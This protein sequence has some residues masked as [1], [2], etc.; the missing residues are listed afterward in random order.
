MRLRRLPHVIMPL[1]DEPFDSWV[2]FMAYDYGATIREMARALG[3]VDRSG[4]PAAGPQSARMW[5]TRLEV[6]QL[7]NLELT[8]GRKADEYSAMTRTVFAAHAIR[9]TSRGRISAFCPSTGVAAR[10]CPECLAD[11]GGRW[12]LSWQFPFGFACLRH[13]RLLVDV[14]PECGQPPRLVG[15]PL[16]LVP[17][18]AHCHNR[19]V[20]PNGD[21]R[22]RCGANLSA[23]AKFVLADSAT[24]EAQRAI[25]R[26]VA[27]G[28]GDFGIY[29][30]LR[31]STIQVLSDMTLLSRA[32]RQALVAG[33]H[34]EWMP[35]TNADAITSQQRNGKVELRPATAE[36]VAIGN[37]VAVEALKDSAR[38]ADLVRGRVGTHTAFDQYSP[39]LREHL[40]RALGRRTRPTTTLQII[41]RTA[42][43][44]PVRAARLPAVLWPEWTARL[45][46]RRLDAEIAGGA[47]A[48]AVVLAGTRLTHGAAIKLLDPDAKGRQ[49]SHVMR[50]LGRHAPEA[51]TVRAIARLAALVDEAAV[52]INFARR[53][54]I[55][56]SGILPRDEW[57][58]I[59]H[60]EN[61]LPG[62]DHRW[63]SARAHLYALASGNR[64]ARA[65]FADEAGFPTLSELSKFRA[66]M[67][68]GVSVAL[69]ASVMGF[70][71][72]RDIDEPVSWMPSIEAV[73]L[74]AEAS[75]S[76]EGS[77][78]RA[79]P[80]QS[81]VDAG[82]A[83]AAYSSGRS[84]EEIADDQG[85]ARQ[86]VGRVLASEG[87]TTRRG[88]RRVA[89]DPDW[90]RKRYLVDR[91]TILELAAEVGVTRT[92]INR[93]LEA[94]G[95][96][97]RARGSSSRAAAIRVDPRAGES[98]ILR[99]ILVGQN[100]TMRAERFLIVARHDTIG[101]AANAMGVSAGVL[102]I[103]M[104]RIGADAGGPL[105]THAQRGLPL[106]LTDLGAEVRRE[107]MDAFDLSEAEDPA[108]PG[109]GCP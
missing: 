34:F 69:E 20:V 3:L 94:A 22:A 65:P 48:A 51:D 74:E 35:A 76:D 23:S 71:G 100:A 95:I 1:P 32:A 15:H 24:R 43:D 17:Q 105:I 106:T 72:S 98:P 62:S 45:A 30:D 101:A 85:V 97:R 26:V 82:R 36:E 80:A 9:L 81:A 96:P 79:R 53:R 14:C 58:E 5:S 99:R 18:P 49:V 44:P 78:P 86:T 68:V 19:P 54:A 104:R 55:D 75:C 83:V 92:T 10:Y 38:V 57:R 107:L 89:I 73:G 64:L 52:Q 8:T 21:V 77:W 66:G 108:P 47:L 39:P 12:R 46:P 84:V 93:H 25:L 56:Y 42:V 37:T 60:R 70:L 27:S 41:S 102:S 33:E 50:S 7:R 87:I 16:T 63:Q 59:C 88:R 61:V 67:P 4:L 91:R 28:V 11:S 103:Q 2:E 31:P 29:A 90:L 109:E 40:S 6:E 13:R